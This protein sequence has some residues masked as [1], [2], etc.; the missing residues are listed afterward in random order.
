M[1]SIR[2]KQRSSSR[3][4]T[5]KTH[6]AITFFPPATRSVS[7]FEEEAFDDEGRLKQSKA[8]SINKIG[9]AMHDLDPVFESFSRTP[10][11]AALVDGLGMEEPLALQSMYIFKQPRIGGEVVFQQ[12]SAFLFTD[13]PQRRRAVVCDR[14]CHYLQWMPVGAA[15]RPSGPGQIPL[16][17]RRGGR[18]RDRRLRPGPRFVPLEAAKEIGRAHV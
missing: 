7:F 18:R 5:R 8:H 11:L 6:P 2:R 16:P 12:D 4:K 1:R 14:G 10:E 3:P 17:A 9:H 13:P 15:G